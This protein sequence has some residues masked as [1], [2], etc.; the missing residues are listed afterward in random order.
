MFTVA[1]PVVICETSKF[2]VREMKFVDV[3]RDFEL[4]GPRKVTVHLCKVTVRT[5]LLC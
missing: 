5:A 3:V 4:P 1:S 2:V